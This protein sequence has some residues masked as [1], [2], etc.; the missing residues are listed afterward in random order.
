MNR[1]YIQYYIDLDFIF[2]F[3]ELLFLHT[4]TQNSFLDH[5][6][7]FYFF[8]FFIFNHQQTIHLSG[9]IC[10]CFHTCLKNDYTQVLNEMDR[11]MGAKMMVAK[12]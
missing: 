9:P 5:N 8:L 11:R 10:T 7:T 4:L 6:Q 12:Q 1:V 3:T 2:F